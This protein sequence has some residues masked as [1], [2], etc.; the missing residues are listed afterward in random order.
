MQP[1]VTVGASSGSLSTEGAPG[2]RS[3][4]RA[5]RGLQA[6]GSAGSRTRLG[7]V[8]VRGVG[9]GA[10]RGAPGAGHVPGSGGWGLTGPESLRKQ[11]VRVFGTTAQAVLGKGR[12][13]LPW[14]GLVVA[15]RHSGAGLGPR[16]WHFSQG[17]GPSGDGGVASPLSPSLSGT[18]APYAAGGWEE[19][20]AGTGSHGDLA[21]EEAAAGGF[22]PSSELGAGCFGGRR[23]ACVSPA[24]EPFFAGVPDDARSAAAGPRHAGRTDDSAGTKLLCRMRWSLR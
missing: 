20:D 15:S 2:H 19:G 5:C 21:L 7:A 11:R 16:R 8:A 14:R 10:G 12:L 24:A 1:G 13:R 6:T 18:P 3:E 4:Q 9:P 22:S 17:K 23:V